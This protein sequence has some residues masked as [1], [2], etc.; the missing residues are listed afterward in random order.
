MGLCCR[1]HMG[2]VEEWVVDEAVFEMWTVLGSK[3]ACVGGSV[4]Q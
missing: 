1:I 2:A 4:G 3:W